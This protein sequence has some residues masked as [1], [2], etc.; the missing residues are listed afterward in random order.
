MFPLL[1]RPGNCYYEPRSAF[2]HHCI[3]PRCPPKEVTGEWSFLAYFACS[4]PF[5]ALFALFSS[6]AWMPRSTYC[7]LDMFSAFAA[8]SM[9]SISSKRIQNETG[10]PLCMD[11][12]YDGSYDRVYDRIA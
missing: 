4:E 8:S 9:R 10:L 1:L 11:A 5:L 2:T 3:T 12:Y 7:D 6:D